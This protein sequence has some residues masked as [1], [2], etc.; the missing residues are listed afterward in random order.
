LKC[1]EGYAAATSKK[2]LA[3]AKSLPDSTQRFNALLGVARGAC[4]V[5]GDESDRISPRR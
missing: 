4:P 2:A 5:P 1:G 3:W